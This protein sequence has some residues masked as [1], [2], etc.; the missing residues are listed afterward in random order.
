MTWMPPNTVYIVRPVGKVGP[1]KIGCTSEVVR[2]VRV[3][4]VWSPLP[5]ELIATAPGTLYDEKHIHR[6]F[7]TH[8]LHGEWFTVAGEVPAFIEHMQAHRR[9]PKWAQC[10]IPADSTYLSRHFEAR[11][12][13]RRPASEQ[14]RSA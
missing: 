6:A 11:A 2:R 8:R 10:D 9:L 12:L 3:L 13:R 7:A 14:S 5:L 1:V 4:Q